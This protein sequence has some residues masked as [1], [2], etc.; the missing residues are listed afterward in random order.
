[1]FEMETWDWILLAAAAYLSVTALVRLM[2]S[3]RDALVEELSWRAD[4]EIRRQALEKNTED[5]RK[6]MER[7]NQRAG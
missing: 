1:M 2:R 4:L 5:R 6:T 7:L 3:R